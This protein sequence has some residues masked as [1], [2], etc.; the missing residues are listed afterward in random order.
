[1]LVLTDLPDCF[2]RW[3]DFIACFDAT[4]PFFVAG[5]GFTGTGF[6]GAAFAA[7][8]TTL[9]GD[10]FAPLLAALRTGTAG[11]FVFTTVLAGAL[12]ALLAAGL[13]RAGAFVFFA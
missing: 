11:R 12:R 3:L 13:V 6:D 9:A 4:T 8:L 10:L 1:M 5:A 2:S 7:G